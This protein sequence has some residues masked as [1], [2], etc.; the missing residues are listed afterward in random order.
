MDWGREE[1]GTGAV[2]EV[3]VCGMEEENVEMAGIGGHLG[4]WCGNLA[5]WKLPGVYEGDTDEVSS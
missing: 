3:G 5:R 2:R 1:V 4:A